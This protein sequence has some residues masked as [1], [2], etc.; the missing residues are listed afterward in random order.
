MNRKL[1]GLS[2][3]TALIAWTALALLWS[4]DIQSAP[5]GDGAYYTEMAYSLFSDHRDLTEVSSL[6]APRILGPAIVGGILKLEGLDI[7]APFTFP[8][9]KTKNPRESWAPA[10]SAA[11]AKIH[12]TYQ[13]MNFTLFT[14]LVFFMALLVPT[15]LLWPL[16]FLVAV[17]LLLTPSFGLVTIFWPVMNDVVA[18]CLFAAGLVLL[19]KKK[20]NLGLVTIGLAGLARE[21]TLM[22]LPFI[23]AFRRFNL[24]RALLLACGPYALSTLFPLFPNSVPLRD[25]SSS[26]VA[27]TKNIFE[28]YFNILK[29]QWAG[30]TSQRNLSQPISMLLNI[31]TCW[32]VLIHL[33]VWRQFPFLLLLAGS[34]V[35][36]ADRHMILL[37]LTAL[38]GMNYVQIPEPWSPKPLI[39]ILSCMLGL[40]IILLLAAQNG[41][42]L[43]VEFWYTLSHPRTYRIAFQILWA[44]CLL[45][46]LTWK[47]V[48]YFRRR[49]IE[50]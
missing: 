12:Q 42:W 39:Q 37:T 13:I 11:Y 35:F 27:E 1:V 43:Q 14:G 10:Q 50:S 32:A 46:F 33:R 16:N 28:A 6:L 2:V 8:Y 4:S 48:P 24:T 47:A 45:G 30:F 17:N 44:S 22:M 21:Q 36:M 34:F 18:L 29:F 49:G 7:S 19:L 9:D 5:S 38:F 15:F 41:S 23:Y 25:S 26:S 3:L 31:G 40:K 20:D